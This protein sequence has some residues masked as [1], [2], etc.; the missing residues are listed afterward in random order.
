MSGAIYIVETVTDIVLFLRTTTVDDKGNRF[1]FSCILLNPRGDI[2]QI[3]DLH[4]TQ[5][6]NRIFVA[7]TMNNLERS[8]FSAGAHPD[9]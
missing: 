3:A 6:L 5:F 9:L 2:V 7:L 8:P 1:T 4:R